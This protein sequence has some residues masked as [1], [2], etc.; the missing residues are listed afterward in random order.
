MDVSQAVLGVEAA[1]AAVV[2]IETATD[3]LIDKAA[4][5]TTVVAETTT[6]AATVK[7]HRMMLPSDLL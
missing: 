4:P 3:V 1:P 7:T 6:A 5:A 2:G